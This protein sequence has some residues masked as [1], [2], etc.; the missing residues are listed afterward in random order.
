MI[1]ENSPS[2]E[3]T[4]TTSSEIKLLSENIEDKKLVL[5]GT[6]GTSKS[7]AEKI[8]A[9]QKFESSPEGYTGPGIYFWAYEN[10]L[11][12][13][14]EIAE[15]WWRFVLDKQNTYNKDTDKSCNVLNVKISIQNKKE[16][17]DITT[18]Y[19]K[20]QILSVLKA[21]NCTKRNEIGKI[22]AAFID[23][24]E[25]LT[26]AKISIL[27]ASVISPPPTTNNKSEIH[28]AYPMSDCYIVRHERHDLLSE[29]AHLQ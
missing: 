28:L 11:N 2:C 24:Y 26:N 22:I 18:Q 20:E 16:Y 9:S 21:Q 17:L 10:D 5:S 12:Y 23:R 7:R 1:F 25:N 29:I 27:K 8:L 4:D 14:K 6:H 13:A 19:Y 15:L 3:N